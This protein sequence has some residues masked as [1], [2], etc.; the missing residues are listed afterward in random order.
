MERSGW[1][2]VRILDNVEVRQV[3]FLPEWVP[4]PNDPCTNIEFDD[5]S[6][7]LPRG[8]GVY[9]D[10]PI[11]EVALKRKKL[12]PLAEVVLAVVLTH[13]PVKSTFIFR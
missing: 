9:F 4:A 13:V 3:E 7:V 2:G 5:E 12:L 11:L 6:I 10:E 1:T 8:R